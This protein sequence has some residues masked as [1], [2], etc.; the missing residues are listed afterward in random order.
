MTKE[1]IL[2]QQINAA[3]K[4]REKERPIFS[5]LVCHEYCIT[6]KLC[7]QIMNMQ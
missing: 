4:E 3:S 7:L 1:D 2:A 5:A 6:T